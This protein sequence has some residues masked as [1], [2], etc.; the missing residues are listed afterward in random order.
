M[1]GPGD[2]RLHDGDADGDADSYADGDTYADGEP[3]YAHG[4]RTGQYY[5]EP[6][7]RRP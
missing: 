4:Q 5:A 3:H 2:K 1:Y 6:Y 7:P